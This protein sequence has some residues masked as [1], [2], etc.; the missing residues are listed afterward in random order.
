MNRQ[1]MT[2]QCTLHSQLNSDGKRE[3]NTVYRFVK[4]LMKKQGSKDCKK[5]DSASYDNA[6]HSQLN[7][8]RGKEKKDTENQPRA[9]IPPTTKLLNTN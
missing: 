8:N 2:M 4:S 3:R 5:D 6:V 1:A 9:C 7:S